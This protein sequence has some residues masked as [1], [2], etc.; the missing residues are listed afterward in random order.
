MKHKRLPIFSILTAV[1]CLGSSP[2]SGAQ[3]APNEIGGQPDTRAVPNTDAPPNPPKRAGKKAP[4]VPK[5]V[6]LDELEE[7]V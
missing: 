1:L 4:V 3:E 6:I 7:V 2:Q 5:P